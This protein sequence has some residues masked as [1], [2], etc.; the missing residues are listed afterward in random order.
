MDI[1]QNLSS[2]PGAT[3]TIFPISFLF[4]I[5]QFPSLFSDRMF[6]IESILSFHT[7][8]PLFTSNNVSRSTVYQ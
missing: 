8:N 3:W 7:D 5:I 6:L 2:L 1:K 4:F